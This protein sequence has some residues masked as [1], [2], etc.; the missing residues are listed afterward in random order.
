MGGE[1]PPH[2]R[3]RNGFR[4]NRRLRARGPRPRR[5]GTAGLAKEDEDAYAVQLPRSTYHAQDFLEA[6]RSRRPAISNI[7][8]SFQSD[9]L[10]HLANIAT[11]TRRRLVWDPRAERFVDDDAAS[12]FLACREM[13]APWKLRAPSAAGIRHCMARRHLA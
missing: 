9:A 13:R 8:D 5:L 7:E 3:S 6:V 4:G 11:R 12:R 10:C 2:L 1:V